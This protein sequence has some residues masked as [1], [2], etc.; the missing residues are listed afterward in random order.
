[1]NLGFLQQ[2]WEKPIIG[3]P[4]KVKALF[5]DTPNRRRYEVLNEETPASVDGI[6]KK[7]KMLKK[8]SCIRLYYYILV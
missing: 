3:E 1:V 8:Y 7:Y 4:S 5:I 2:E 6:L